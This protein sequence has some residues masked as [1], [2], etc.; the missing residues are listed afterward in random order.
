MTDPRNFP[1]LLSGGWRELA[2]EFFR[3]GIEIAWLND[4]GEAGGSALLRYQPG[5]AAPEHLHQ[6]L[7]TIVV[8]EGSQS[9][10]RGT[11]RTGDVVTNPPGYQH[12]VWTDEGCVVLICWARP[13]AFV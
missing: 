5:A 7:E 6:G 10:E 3:D 2:F 9:D 13:V 1:S 8:L 4:Q 11:Y 12:S